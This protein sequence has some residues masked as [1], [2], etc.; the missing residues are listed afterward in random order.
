[1]HHERQETIKE[2]EA[3][4]ARG[5]KDSDDSEEGSDQVEDDHFEDEE[6]GM[7]SEE[8]WKKHQKIFEVAG[9]KLHSGK[10]LT[11]AEMKELDID[12]GDFD[13]D[14]EDSDYEYAGGDMSLYDSRMENV[15]ELVLLKQ[16]LTDMQTCNPSGFTTLMSGLTDSQKL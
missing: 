4:I 14:E 1:M 8:E 2:D 10:P 15:D 16:M 9:S 12:A 13:D 5:G 6:N 7:D 11:A 3:Y